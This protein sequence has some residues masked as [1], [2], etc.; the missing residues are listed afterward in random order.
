MTY[1]Q[2]F[3]AATGYDPYPYLR[4]LAEADLIA[5]VLAYSQWR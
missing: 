2:F 3:R 4:R 5:A 1:R